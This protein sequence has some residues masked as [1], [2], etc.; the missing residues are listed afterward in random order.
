VRVRAGEFDAFKLKWQS[1]WL[2]T[3]GFSGTTESTYW[4]A[5]SARAVVKSELWITGQPENACELV[6]FQLQP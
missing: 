5:P 4:Y 6:E 3:K 2:D 1:G